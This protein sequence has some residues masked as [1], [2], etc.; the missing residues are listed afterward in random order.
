MQSQLIL[1][2]LIFSAHLVTTLLLQQLVQ[3]QVHRWYF[4]QLDV[5]HHL[6]HQFLQ[7]RLQLTQDL[8]EIRVT[9]LTLMQEELLQ[10]IFHLKMQLRSS[11][12]SY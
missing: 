10:M 6:H 5:E 11:S 4:S 12:S 2:D 7:L 9:G 1:R 3:L 8:Q